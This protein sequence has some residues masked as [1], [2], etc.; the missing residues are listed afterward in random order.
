MCWVSL[1]A[2]FLLVVFLIR[3]D[4]KIPQKEIILKIDVKNK[5]NICLP[6]DDEFSEK[7]FFDF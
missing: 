5:V 4:A 3:D 7:S 6:E 2:L 1:A